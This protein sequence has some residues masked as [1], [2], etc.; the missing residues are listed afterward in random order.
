MFSCN[1]ETQ[2]NFIQQNQQHLCQEDAKLMNTEDVLPTEN[3]YLPSSFLGSFA[4]LLAVAA[5][6]GRPTFF[7]TMTCNMMWPEIVSQLQLGQDFTDIPIMV[8]H[9]FKHKLMLLLQ[10]L[11]TMF[12]NAGHI[13][14]CIHCVEFQKC[15]LPHAHILLKYAVDC[16]II[17][18]QSTV[19]MKMQMASASGGV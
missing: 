6:L 12:V 8:A 17:L 14:Y 3:I 9:V 10:M 1:L 15:R 19:S 2:L 13:L 7:V 5:A 18:H 16:N 4:D 11:K